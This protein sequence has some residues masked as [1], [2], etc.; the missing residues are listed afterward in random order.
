MSLMNPALLSLVLKVFYGSIVVENEHYIPRDGTACIVCSNHP[1]SLTD[2]ILLISAVPSKKRNFLR[3]T[4]KDTQFG[5]RTLISWFIESV[6][7]LPIKRRK[8][9][10]E[11][12]ADNT[13]VMASLVQA[14]SEGDAVCLFPE[15]MSRY[16]PTVAPLKTGVARLASDVLSKRRDDPTFEVDILTCSITYMHREHFRSDVLVSFNP[17]TRLRPGTHPSLLSPASPSTVRSLTS[18][19]RTQIVAGTIDAPSWGAVRTA[20][21]AARIY[22]PLGTQMRLGDW[23]R[24]VGAFAE[25][26]GGSRGGLAS[27]GEWVEGSTVA[28]ASASLAPEGEKERME[29]LALELKLTCRQDYQDTLNE[30]GLTDARIRYALSYPGLVLRIGI[31][32]A[33][34]VFLTHLALPGIIPWG[35]IFATTAFATSR[36]K[37][38]GPVW[39]VFDEIAQVK[40]V[41]G[42]VSGTMVVAAIGLGVRIMLGVSIVWA[43]VG[44]AAWM[45]MSLR[46]YEDATAAWRALLELLRLALVIERPVLERV[47]AT[48]RDLQGQVHAVAVERLGLPAE[49]ERWF[50]ETETESEGGGFRSREGKGRA[51]GVWQLG[52]KYFSPRRRRKRD[53]NETLRWYDVTE[54]P[55]DR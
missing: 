54:F 3:M 29:S 26:F 46:W 14:L 7:T 30:L 47:R 25:Y 15:G 16:Y 34:A 5:R 53:W 44:A 11:G 24:V 6:G 36:F 32:L 23:V 4:A 20:K 38:T 40:L 19:L 52:V 48:R 33:W 49:P 17:P 13:E 22:S 28:E 27:V 43:M 8:D 2:A 41:Y 55:G 21:T 35:P 10:L 12:V 45:W 1:N 39:D 42:L 51:A 37:Q 18:Y 50:L 31:R 9:H